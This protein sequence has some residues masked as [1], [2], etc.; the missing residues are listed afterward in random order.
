[1]L[2][3]ELRNPLA[4]IRNA[5][6]LLRQPA[7]DARARRARARH[8]STARSSTW[9]AWSTTCSTCRAS[10]AARSSCSRS[11]SSLPT[12]SRDAVETGA[13]ADRARAA[14]ALDAALPGGAAVSSTAT[15][16]PRAGARQP[17]EQRRQVH[18]RPAAT[19]SVARR[20][21]GRPGV[22]RVRDNGIGIAR[23]AAAARL[24][25]VR[26]GRRARSTAP[27]GGLGIG[28]T[29][30]R[31]LVE[32]HGGRSRPTSDG[33]GRGSEFTVAPA[34]LSAAEPPRAGPRPTPVERLGRGV[35]PRGCWSSTTTS[36]PPRALAAAARPAGPRGRRSAHD[37]IAALA[38]AAERSRPTSC[39]S[40]SACPA[41]TAT[42]WRAGCASAA[43][44]PRA[45]GRA[46]R[47]R[48]GRGPSARGRGRLRPPLRQAGRPARDPG[49]H[50]ARPQ[51]RRRAHARS[52]PHRRRGIVR[53]R[54]APGQAV[55]LPS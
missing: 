24:R 11:R 31:S 14:P 39:C 25:P 50:R 30:V 42:R 29:L 1:M 19:S 44:Q 20:R 9:R 12:S 15:D 21:R 53:L 52:P 2:A 48:P 36:T 17:A 5:L 3:H 47:L 38:R 7:R 55:D 4:P 13:P 54:P 8:R 41:S 46:H 10:P 6:E 32:L 28:L 37:G 33:P 22:I 23:R 26:A 34:A 35:R 18:R 51:H 40:T 49:R 45:A 16:A 27:Q 43:H